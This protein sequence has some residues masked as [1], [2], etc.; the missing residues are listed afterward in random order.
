MGNGAVTHSGTFVTLCCTEW[1]GGSTL[2]CKT[3]IK[4][5]THRSATVEKSSLWVGLSTFDAHTLSAQAGQGV[6]ATVAV[7]GVPGPEAAPASLVLCC[8]AAPGGQSLETEQGKE[9]PQHFSVKTQEKLSLPRKSP[10]AVQLWFPYLQS[11]I[12]FY[13][14]PACCYL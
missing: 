8:D 12:Y 2:L 7:M 11:N 9:V 13:C 6:G 14:P 10:S 4:F 1:R 5:K 3:S